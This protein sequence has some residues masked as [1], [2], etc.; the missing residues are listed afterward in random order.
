[1]VKKIS[2]IVPARNE[3]GN[4]EALIKRIDAAMRKN[5]IIYEI[6]L[7]DDYSTDKT[8][9]IARKL[10]TKHPLTIL[11]KNGKPGKAQSLIEGFSHAKYELLCMIDADLQYPP[12]SIEE[13]L[14]KIEKG[15][16]IVVANRK[17]KKT[18]VIRKFLSTSYLY[19]F[20]KILHGFNCD[21]QS[22]MKIF[23]KEI[24]ERITLN[25]S[26]WTF[27]LEFLLKAR[28]AGYKINTINI[29]FAERT[30]GHTKIKLFNA[31]SQIGWTAL[32]YKFIRSE[33]VPFHPLM[34]KKRGKGFH[35]NGQEFVHHSNL[36]YEDTA[37]FRLTGRHKIIMLEIAAIII[38]SLIFNWHATLVATVAV[39]TAL[40]FFDLIFNLYLVYRSF[41]NPVEIQIADEEVESRNNWPSYTIFCPLYKE[42][43]VVPQFVTAMSRL[44]YPKNKLQVMLLLEEDDKETIRHI[45]GQGLPSYFEIVV[46]PNSQP[47]TK[48]KAC[49]YGLLK[50]KGE[51]SVIYDAEDVPDILQL[52]KTVLAFERGGK[53][54]MCIQAKLNFYNPHQ[55]LLSRLFTA[56]YSLWFDLVLTGLQSVNAP[57]PLG[58]TS[59]H[60]RTDGLIEL[61]G[62]DSFNVT[63]D[64]DLGMR[65]V[66]AGY[67]TA[68]VD[69]V[70][71]E[72]ANSSYLNWIKQRS[73][74]IKGYMQTYLV[75]CR[76]LSGF[77]KNGRYLLALNFQLI[78]GGKVLSMFINPLMW[79]TTIAYFMLRTQAGPFIESLFPSWVLYMGVFSLIFGNFL[80]I[81]YY[82]IGCA[83]H[84]HDQLLKYVFFVP[85]YWLMMSIAAWYAVYK[86]I[87]APHHWAKTKHGLHINNNKA[88][89]HAQKVIGEE[90]IDD[91]FVIA[92]ASLAVNQ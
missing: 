52:K 56:E 11:Y 14:N 72:E 76:D 90:L 70:T 9:T 37:F 25:P 31:I 29:V 82:M 64:C 85:L 12:E 18:H 49:N 40:Y 33:I 75:H 2:I 54:L 6:I 22:G 41:S 7:I 1:M 89:T 88:L 46:V 28:N 8:I 20:G 83:K 16:D 81:Y 53:S 69:S 19:F 58:G 10:A 80:Y 5:Q 47:K 51:Y 26:P 17:I 66:K 67:R 15:A 23:R 48:P 77:T 74:W 30:S 92:P 84:G 36:H 35:H 38:L 91:Q 55:N 86:L 87:T 13:M 24:I 73:R 27:D 68:V 44:D 39:L 61:K 60:F 59:N 34:E 79:T 57:I 45:K 32:K 71:L 50:T 78:V 65:L 63:E 3:E 43:Q 42:W 4:I 62:W 21:V